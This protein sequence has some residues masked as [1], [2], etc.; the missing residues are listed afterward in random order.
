MRGLALMAS[1]VAGPMIGMSNVI[2]LI[3]NKPKQ[4]IQPIWRS[5]TCSGT[6]S[7]RDG[8]AR[9]AN[10]LNSNIHHSLLK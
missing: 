5:G 6:R 2:M 8:P 9:F 1:T 3:W 10:A 4:M 7:S